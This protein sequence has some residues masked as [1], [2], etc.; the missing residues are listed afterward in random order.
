M[1]LVRFCFVNFNLTMSIKIVHTTSLFQWNWA[2][3]RIND[4]DEIIIIII[5]I[6]SDLIHT[7]FKLVDI[8]SMVV[9]VEMAG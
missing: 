5:I 8:L 2:K 3:S 9:I 4:V 6:Y 1:L 7:I